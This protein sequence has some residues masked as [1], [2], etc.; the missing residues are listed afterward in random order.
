MS[1]EAVP[2]NSQAYRDSISLVDQKT[3]DRA[4]VYPKKPKGNLYT[5][6]TWFSVFLMA[7]MFSGPFIKLNEHPILLLNIL[8][9]K[10]IILGMA[11][12]PQ[13]LPLFALLMLTFVVF[14]MVF[15]V[16]FGRLWC[17]WACPQT[18]FMEMLFRKIE[19][20]IEGD[21][22]QQL[23]L[24]DAPWNTSKIFKKTIKHILFYILSVAIAN[25]FLAYLIGVDEVKKL[26]TD[27]PS[28]HIGQFVAL[29][30]F[31]TVFYFVF[32]KFREIVCIVICPYGR[33]QGLMLD[34]NSIVVAYDFVRGEPRGIHKKDV[35]NNLGDCVD[36][37]RCVHVCP[38]GID[39]RNGTQLECVNCTACIDEC[40][41]VMTHINKPK[42]LIRYASQEQISNGSSK[43][44][45]YRSGAY[46]AILT[47][48]VSLLSYL[49]ITRKD[50]TT[51]VL[52]TPGMLY[53][54]QDN[55]RVSNMY[56]FEVVNKTF[57][58]QHIEVKMK[59]PQ[60]AE[61]KMVDRE[62]PKMELDENALVKGSFFI[63]IPKNKIKKNNSEVII[64]VYSNGKLMNQITTNFVGPVQM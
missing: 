20:F 9:R 12:W 14:I 29:V 5:G 4:W 10:F 43:R 41:D 24:D 58:T 31:S 49:I 8:Q 35:E 23:K 22:K 60:E 54:Q 51:D 11:F 17:G 6:R 39:I 16:L 32:S 13:D 18:I 2:E 21:Y 3:G 33:L 48:L 36:C 46:I 62:S 25:T 59:N 53:Q 40:N 7:L 37:K 15:T 44:I 34:K 63:I 57:N 19:Y 30:I 38:T 47:I 1:L 52:R 27:G 50:V 28:E 42:G 64:E 61:L 26:V 55:D 45:T 56:N